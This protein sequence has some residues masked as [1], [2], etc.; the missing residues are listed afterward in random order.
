MQVMRAHLP[1]LLAA[2]VLA[3]AA[4]GC[5]T[6]S[7]P[8]KPEAAL[9]GKPACFFLVNFSGDWT[10]LSDTTLIVA[11][12]LT[13]RQAYLIKLFEPIYD[14]R[15]R[16]RLGFQDVERTGRICDNSMDNL[17]VREGG[18]L[19][20]PIVAVR[21]ITPVE[22]RQLLLAAGLKVPAYLQKEI[23]SGK[24]D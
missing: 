6:S 9:P 21:R 24:S 2:A 22:Q 7:P 12:P 3:A 10:V 23:S 4:A 20:V 15:F 14:L 1:R 8:S 18:Q 17:V 19:P 16:Q 11:A 5:A 13:A